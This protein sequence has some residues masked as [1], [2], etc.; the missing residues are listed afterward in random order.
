[1]TVE[2]PIYIEAWGDREASVTLHEITVRSFD[3]D[4]FGYLE[5]NFTNGSVVY[6]NGRLVREV[7]RVELESAI[8][9]SDRGFGRKMKKEP[10]FKTDIN[11]YYEILGGY[12]LEEDEIEDTK[13]FDRE[14]WAKAVKTKQ[15]KEEEMKNGVQ[16]QKAPQRGFQRE[17]KKETKN[18]PKFPF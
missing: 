1:M 14:I 2:V 10:K 12:L 11:E 8:D 17:T 7:K 6:L 16:E 3:E 18:V 9:D 13:A 4:V 15:E 5:D